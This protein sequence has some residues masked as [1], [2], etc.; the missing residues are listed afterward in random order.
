MSI[1]L[2]SAQTIGNGVTMR[3]NN[4]QYITPN[5]L[6]KLFELDA[7][8]YSSPLSTWEDISGNGR[9]ATLHG[10]VPYYTDSVG[11]YFGFIGQGSNYIDIAGSETGWGIADTAPNATLSMWASIT[12]DGYYQHVAGWRGGGFHFY[13]LMLNGN[14][15]GNLT[16]A[17]VLTNIST[18]DAVVD[19]TSYFNTW[20][21]I[22]FVADIA[23]TRTRLYL[24][25][26]PA[27]TVNGIAGTWVSG[28]IPFRIGSADGDGYPLH[29]Y[30]GGAAAYSRALTDV[31]VLS[32]F[33]RTKTRYVL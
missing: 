11:G 18:Y 29:G 13:F 10:T 25:G 3:G 12:P 26:N 7:S 8:T 19:Y 30:I 32:E 31:E 2:R 20:T 22:T 21:Y 15:S 24:N 14:P 23:N 6:N 17:R 33:N 4:T 28:G 1:T 5:P 27:G 9:H 16:E